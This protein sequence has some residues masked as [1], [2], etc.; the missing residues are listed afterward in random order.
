MKRYLLIAGALGLMALTGCG[1]GYRY[2]RYDYAYGPPPPPRVEVYGRQ[3]GPDHV[4]I[5]GYWGNAGGRYAWN[6][7]SWA[8]PPHRG[9]RW[10]EGRWDR[11]G[12]GYRYRQGHWR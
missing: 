4:W 8:R 12:R 5:R 10:H 9:A 3:P 11:D 2:D 6:P 1:N 7:G